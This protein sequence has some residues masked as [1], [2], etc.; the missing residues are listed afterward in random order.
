MAR[1]IGASAS[2][3]AA[4]VPLASAVAPAKG[5]GVRRCR[6]MA[7]VSGGY[8]AAVTSAATSVAP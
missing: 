4:K 2:D 8:S 7:G 5:E 1:P 6:T 3:V